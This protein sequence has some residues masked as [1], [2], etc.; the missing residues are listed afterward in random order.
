VSLN[1]FIDY[2]YHGRG[3]PGLALLLVIYRLIL[4]TIV[5]SV[6]PIDGPPP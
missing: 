6:V 1:W 5:A 3:C 4:G 2:H